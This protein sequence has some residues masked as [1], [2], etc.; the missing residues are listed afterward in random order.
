MVASEGEAG[1]FYALQLLW[2]VRKFSVLKIAESQGALQGRNLQ[3]SNSSHV[4]LPKQQGSLAHNSI[5]YG[6]PEG[7]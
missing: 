7:P 3:E 1:A 5:A 2:Q 6:R 4:T